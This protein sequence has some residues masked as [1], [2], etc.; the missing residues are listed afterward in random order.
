MNSTN[1]N[2]FIANNFIA[3]QKIF[4]GIQWR[5]KKVKKVQYAPKRYNKKPIEKRKS[6]P[7][8]LYS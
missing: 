3:L 1:T 4:A 8:A 5:N 6:T 2:Q 7:H